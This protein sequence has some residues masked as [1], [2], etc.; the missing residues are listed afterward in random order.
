MSLRTEKVESQLQAICAQAATRYARGRQTLNKAKSNPEGL[1]TVTRAD[2]APDLRTARIYI[3]FL[4]KK[5]RNTEQYL[6]DLRNFMQDAV[7]SQLSSKFTPRLQL[8][9]D[10][11]LGYAAHISQTL[12]Q[13]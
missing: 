2:V 1:V 6:E 5:P 8:R 3:S 9:Q 10:D 11:S 4:G 12:K 13:L 7:R